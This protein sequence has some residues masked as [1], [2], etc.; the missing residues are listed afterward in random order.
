LELCRRGDRP[1]SAASVLYLL[2]W[3]AGLSGDRQRARAFLREA[4]QVLDDE[5]QLSVRADVL[6]EAA[7]TLEKTAP[8]T[9]GRLLGAA[10]A[11]FALRGISRGVPARERI[12]SLQ[13]RLEARLGEEALAAALGQG[14]RLSIDEAI[15]EALVAVDT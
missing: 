12:E 2:A 13:S 5:A 7:L 4:L 3:E 11:A 10:D 14:A 15:A 6:S 8:R 1:A 9:A